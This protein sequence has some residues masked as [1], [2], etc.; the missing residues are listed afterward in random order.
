MNKRVFGIVGLNS[1]FANWNADFDKYP[2]RVNG[3][4]YA[5]DKALKYVIRR[6]FEDR[7]YNVFYRKEAYQKKSGKDSK[8]EDK[9]LV[10]V[11]TYTE[12]FDS[13]LKKI[14]PNITEI[15]AVTALEFLLGFKDIKM[16]GTVATLKQKESTVLKKD[17]TLGIRGIIQF[18]HGFNLNE[19]T[20]IIREQIT[21]Q[22]AS[23]VGQ[24]TTIGD[25]VMVDDADYFYS[26]SLVEENNKD[27]E[28]LVQNRIILELSDDEYSLFKEACL[29][30]VDN[31]DSAIK[32]GCSNSF[33]CF[34][35]TD[36]EV[37]M[38]QL[39]EFIKLESEYEKT[40]NLDELI[41][42]LQN[43][44]DEIIKTEIYYRPSI[45]KLKNV[46]KIKEFVEV[47]EF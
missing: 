40:L 27:L 2:K 23:N 31:Y 1:V 10:A 44:K 6:F 3:K 47:K 43:R 37:C 14:N 45:L 42:Y 8:K 34:V 21:S 36:R 17:F 29:C 46:D 35:E 18:T 4:L 38:P 25:M 9:G 28:K 5:S 32:A 12:R 30:A 41:N 15:D 19:N 24:M 11:Q 22:F 33:A 13:E 16:F 7:G 20:Q 26:F 39:H